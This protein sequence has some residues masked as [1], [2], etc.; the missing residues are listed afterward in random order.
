MAYSNFSEKYVLN[1]CAQINFY[2]FYNATQKSE[3][4]DKKRPNAEKSVGFC[5]EKAEAVVLWNEA[6]SHFDKCKANG[7]DIGKLK[8][9]HSYK[10]TE[11]GAISLRQA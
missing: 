10:D 2:A 8:T 4:C 11:D 3:P 9:V 5:M 1:T 7:V 6:K